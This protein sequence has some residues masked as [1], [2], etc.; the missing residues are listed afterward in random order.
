LRRDAGEQDLQSVD[1]NIVPVQ[2]RA[3]A[4]GVGSAGLC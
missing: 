2:V 4:T 3:R 1:G